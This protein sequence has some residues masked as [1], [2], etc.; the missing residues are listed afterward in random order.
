MS[1]LL[2]EIREQPEVVRRLLAEGYGEI[3]RLA[4]YVSGRD[5]R[6]VVIAARGTSD[7]AATYGKYVLG[8]W[9]RLPVALAAPSLFSVYHR[10]LDLRS[11]LVVGISQSGA[12]PDILAVLEE[13]RR[14]GAP[15]LAITNDPASPLALAAEG[16]IDLCAGP[17]RSVAATKT[18][19]AQIAAL[20][21]LSA[22]LADDAMR[23]AE[24]RAVPAA[25]EAALELSEGLATRAQRYRYMDEC[26]VIGR[27]YNYATA[28]ELALKL[29][30]L[31]YVGASPYSS[32]DF[33]HG[34]IAM[35]DRGFP[36][37]LAATQ[38]RVLG[39]LLDLMDALDERGAELIVI[40]D[41]DAALSRAHTGLRLPEG[42]PEWLSPL[43]AVVPGQLLAYHLAT[44]K[45]L[46]PECPRGLSKV[47]RTR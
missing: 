41:A 14:Q 18:Y 19:T 40:S 17:E 42:V 36:V 13:A 34:P 15:T 21:L 43:V 16:V 26:A 27:G 45:G 1:R 23:L 47:T 20:A 22:A 33:R 2:Q 24:V 46:D 11:S 35:V 4:G 7:N 44:A 5:V 3:E 37:L 8:A 31:T 29:K 10:P 38:G 25:L 9:N 30:E 32:A 12:S 6:Y 28:S 39:D